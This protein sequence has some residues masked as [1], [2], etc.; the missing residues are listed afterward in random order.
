MSSSTPFYIVIPAAG[1]G[2]RFGAAVPKQYSDLGSEMLASHTLRTL[3]ACTGLQR[4]VV[5]LHPNDTWFASLPEA[6][7]ARIEV[8]EGGT[9]RVDSVLNGLQHLDGIAADSWVL[10]HDMARPCIQAD[11][12][13]KLLV[14]LLDHPTGGILALPVNDTVKRANDELEVVQTLDRSRLWLA[15]TPQMFRYS[16]LKQALT[17]GLKRGL[18]ITDE[19]SAMEAA[20]HTVALI[21]GDA[22][23]IKVTRPDDLLLAAL[24]MGI[25]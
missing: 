5:V 14:A 21:E 13:E 24:Y 7:D 19:A 1:I 23:N 10:V 20:G 18:P 9:E 22:R 25:R 3:L 11:W 2:S 12:V 4:L 6:S 17:E 15:Q 16:L 8:V